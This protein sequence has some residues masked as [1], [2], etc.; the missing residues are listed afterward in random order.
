MV[1]SRG[2]R[3]FEVDSAAGL[4]GTREGAGKG[5][6]ATHRLERT[7][8]APGA[9]RGPRI[10]TAPSPAWRH[11]CSRAHGSDERTVIGRDTVSPCPGGRQVVS[12]TA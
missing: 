9:L 1:V 11:E 2:G 8:A 5:A 4:A 10:P 12:P 3:T 6:T 7:D